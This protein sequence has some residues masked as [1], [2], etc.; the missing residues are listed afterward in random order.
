MR[1]DGAAAPVTWLASR[2]PGIAG[3]WLMG[4]GEARSEIR[5]VR[6]KGMGSKPEAF[7]S[8]KLTL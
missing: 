3:I 4:G 1:T 5:M 6:A 2:E 8:C 7:G